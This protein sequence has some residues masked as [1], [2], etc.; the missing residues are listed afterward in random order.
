MTH[1][2]GTV[3]GPAMQQ[4]AVWTYLHDSCVPKNCGGGRSYRPPGASAS[5]SGDSL[6]HLS[7]AELSVLLAAADELTTS[8]LA[9]A[10][11]LPTSALAAADKLPTSVLAAADELPTSALA[12]ADC[13]ETLLLAPPTPL[14]LVAELF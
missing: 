8:A 1:Q 9:V 4:E 2:D 3:G 10:D 14:L 7:A 5:L 12:A 11:K 13:S 6:A